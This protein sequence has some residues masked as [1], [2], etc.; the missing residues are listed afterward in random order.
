[1]IGDGSGDANHAA[2]G[3][4]REHLPDGRWGSVD[5]A[6]QICGRQRPKVFR[7]VV[8][9][10]LCEKDACVVHQCI[11]R[12]EALYCRCSDPLRLRGES[13]ITIHKGKSLGALQLALTTDIAR[14][15][16]YVVATL[17]EQ[18]RNLRANAL[19][20]SSHNDGLLLRSHLSNSPAFGPCRLRGS[21]EF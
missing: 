19:G 7:R 15:G 12:A 4:L 18:V 21:S 1:M 9:E 16:H 3:F 10:G 14:V 20:C 2:A 8:C 6:V 17:E 5:E 11:E 13:D